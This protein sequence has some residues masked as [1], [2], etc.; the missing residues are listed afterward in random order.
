MPELSAELSAKG[1]SVDPASISRW[2]IR[3][4]YRFK[5]TLL[6][7]EQDRPDVRKTRES[8]V[9]KRQPSMG[10]EQHRLVFIDETGT[11]TKMTRLRGR[12]LRGQRLKS[13]APFGHW[14]TQTFIAGLRC[15]G[16]TAPFVVDRPMNRRIFETY[17]SRRLTLPTQLGPLE[18]AGAVMA[19]PAVLNTEDHPPRDG[20][21]TK[22]GAYRHSKHSQHSKFAAAEGREGSARDGALGHPRPGR[23]RSTRRGAGTPPPPLTAFPAAS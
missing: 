20:F 1:T 16:L 3:N 10:L 19:K 22:T 18:E 6:A 15:H 7:S 23:R 9:A 21:G 8:W 17:V 11:T 2:F 5:K 14:K 12:C 13:K 4:G